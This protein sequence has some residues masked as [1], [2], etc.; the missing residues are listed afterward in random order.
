[1]CHSLSSF[2]N[3]HRLR[4]L[5]AC[6][7]FC[8]IAGR[9][10]AQ[11]YV[12]DST[13]GSRGYGNGQF[14]DHGP[15]G[16]TVDRNGSLFVTDPGN[17]RVEKFDKTGAYLGQFP[18]IG[19][20]GVAV[21]SVGN[22]YVISDED[23]LLKFDKNGTFLSVISPDLRSS[24]PAGLWVDSSDNVFVA[25][26]YGNR[27]LK[28]DKRGNLLN[29][30]GKGLFGYPGTETFYYHGPVGITVDSVGNIYACDPDHGRVQEF[31]KTGKLIGINVGR[32][33]YY[34][35]FYTPVAVAV[36]SSDNVFIADSAIVQK[37]DKTGKYLGVIGSPG[38]GPKQYYN[39]DGVAVDSSGSVF[40]SDNYSL[41]VQKYRLEQITDIR[42]NVPHLTSY[43]DNT[44]ALKQSVYVKGVGKF[45]VSGHWVDKD[46]AQGHQTIRTIQS[47]T[48]DLSS[49]K[50]VKLDDLTNTGQPTG[51]HIPRSGRHTLQF[52]I[53]SPVKIATSSEDVTVSAFVP[54][55]NGWSVK[56][57]AGVSTVQIPLS[58]WSDILE[59]FGLGNLQADY[60]YWRFVGVCAGI[61]NADRD[62][63]LRNLP[64]PPA[65]RAKAFLITNYH[66]G[67]NDW[68]RSNDYIRVM[69]G[70]V[71]P[72]LPG[73][74]Y[75]STLYSEAAR[76]Q[77]RL[78]ANDP[79]VIVVLPDF[80]STTGLHAV[81]ATAAFFS[82]NIYDD[83]SAGLPGGGE[84]SQMRLF[85]IC[86]S[87]FPRAE[88]RYF[89]AFDQGGPVFR[90][91]PQPGGF[92]TNL[93][94]WNESTFLRR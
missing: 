65:G 67:A 90:C 70:I 82:A 30:F 34:G 46:L 79:C 49:G 28:F 20:Y 15:F 3:R 32:D 45:A 43:S 62:Y 66:D 4:L 8:L 91:M 80:K 22:I 92:Y 5:A 93:I 72:R 23:G 42:L 11:V 81:I 53:D 10:G 50:W 57:S 36:D 76:I 59:L 55:V 21:D 58:I 19:P 47:V 51:Y 56:N 74:A 9:V 14:D 26:T 12:Y 35:V 39:P 31:D 54:Y 18:A 78:K 73:S 1:M 71:N 37:F 33:S 6:L 48:V 17:F 85:S 77:N 16:L 24:G 13:I 69:N 75:A 52:V 7:L 29:I 84:F 87:N 44:R 88:D 41:R 89:G 38:T 61:S 83:A 94:M 40:I 27:L 60:L 25:D 63:F 2:G 68:W 64:E 86:D